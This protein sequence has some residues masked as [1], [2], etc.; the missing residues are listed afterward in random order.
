M[1]FIVCAV[2]VCA[3]DCVQDFSDSDVYSYLKSVLVVLKVC[4]FVDTSKT[5]SCAIHGFHDRV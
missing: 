2:H 3:L 5:S 4:L 1:A